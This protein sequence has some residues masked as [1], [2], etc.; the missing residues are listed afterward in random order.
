MR[1]LLTFVWLGS[2]I[3]S[4][5]T[6]VDPAKIPGALKTLGRHAGE[7]TIP[8]EVTPLRPALNFGFR[9]QAGY[10]VRLPLKLYT[11]KGHSLA[12]MTT[13]TPQVGDRKPPYLLNHFRLPEV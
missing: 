4:A 12:L 9:F 1:H 6:L 13:I 2:T 3:A 5:Q 8:C 11:G 10:V 7:T